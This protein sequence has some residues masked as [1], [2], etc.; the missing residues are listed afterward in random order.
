MVVSKLLCYL[1]QKI[2]NFVKTVSDV[3]SVLLLTTSFLSYRKSSLV[4]STKLAV[5]NEMIY[6]DCVIQSFLI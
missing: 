3:L 6:F 1:Q 2:L 4:M 5:F